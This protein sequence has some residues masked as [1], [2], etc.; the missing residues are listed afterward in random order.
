M[1]GHNGNPPPMGPP[2]NESAF[3]MDPEHRSAVQA[4]I[5]FCPSEERT[6]RELRSLPKDQRE[7]VWA[8]MTGHPETQH[9]RR[10]AESPALV[11]AQVRLMTDE[12][13]SLLRLE[14]TARGGTQPPDHDSP[15]A[16]TTMTTTTSS[17]VHDY[18]AYREA[19]RQNPTYVESLKVTF[20]R[21]EDFHPRAAAVRML[22]YFTMKRDLFVTSGRCPVSVLARDVRHD[23]LSDDDREALAAGGMQLLPVADHAGRAVVF[24]RQANYRYREHNNMVRTKPTNQNAVCV[25]VC[26]CEREREREIIMFSSSVLQ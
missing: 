20:L 13:Q 19:Y 8:D 1:A 9:Y 26:L 11:E 7:Q 21:A 16:T 10:T 14:G 17:S 3:L 5:L 23:D 15:S 24:T 4:R 18:Q 22:S 6:Q 12:I 2:L 25:C